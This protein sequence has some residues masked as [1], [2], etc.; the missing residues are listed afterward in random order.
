M[1][2][3]LFEDSVTKWRYLVIAPD[4]NEGREIL[5][6]WKD[7]KHRT[8]HERTLVLKQVCGRYTDKIFVPPVL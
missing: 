7:E 4:E 6:K 2:L 1:Q 8:I 3:Y 5:L